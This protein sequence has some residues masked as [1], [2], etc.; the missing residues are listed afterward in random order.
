MKI[1]A[2]NHLQGKVVA[3]KDGA[4]NAVVSVDIGGGN[5]ISS[6]I[7]MDSVRR[8]GLEVGSEAYA[9]IKASSV[10]IAVD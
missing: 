10:M 6:V 5:I 8:L 4:V 1:S 7:T 2:S 3:I 9:V